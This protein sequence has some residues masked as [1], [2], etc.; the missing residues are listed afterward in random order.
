VIVGSA[1]VGRIEGLLAT[2][3][4]IEAEVSEFLHGLRVAIDRVPKTPAR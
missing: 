3:E 2:P 4:R 1:L